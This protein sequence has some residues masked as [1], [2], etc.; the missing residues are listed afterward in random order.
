MPKNTILSIKNNHDR[1]K[2]LEFYEDDHK[3]I[4]TN[5]KGSN[6]TSVT[7]WNHTHFSIQGFT[8]YPYGDQYLDPYGYP[9]WRVPFRSIRVSTMEGSI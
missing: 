1:D 6:Y 9:Q 7:T 2:F 4:I 3:Y 5:D 8:S